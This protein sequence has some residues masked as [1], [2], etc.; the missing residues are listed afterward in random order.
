[1]LI[2]TYANVVNSS[3]FGLQWLIT[4]YSKVKAS[5]LTITTIHHY[6]CTCMY[7]CAVNS[8][9]AAIRILLSKLQVRVRLAKKILH[10]LLIKIVA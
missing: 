3:V 6:Y 5:S 4:H 10:T 8:G 1:M 9:E 7:L 2:C